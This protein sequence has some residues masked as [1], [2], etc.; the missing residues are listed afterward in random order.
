MPQET[1]LLDNS[2][3]G[4]TAVFIAQCESLRPAN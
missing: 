4:M 1:P 2:S 3:A